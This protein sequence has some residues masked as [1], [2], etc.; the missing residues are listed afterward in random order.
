MRVKREDLLTE[1]TSVKPGLSVK[2]ELMQSGCFVFRKG[3]VITFNEEICCKRPSSL[4]IEGAVKA[5][6]LLMVLEKTKKEYLDLEVQEGQ[7]VLQMK[8]ASAGVVME[9]EIELPVSMVDDPEDWHS[10]SDTFI[11][12]MGMVRHCAG[13]DPS[14]FYL[15]CVHIGDKWVEA[16]DNL[17]IARYR[18][19]TGVSE[20]VLLLAKS[21]GII[22]DDMREV[23]EFSITKSF[24]HFRNSEGLVISCRRYL[25]DFPQLGKHLKFE[26]QNVVLP[27]GAAEAAE[28]AEIFSREYKDYNKV[29]VTISP[30]GMKI[31][32]DGMTGWYTASKRLDYEGESLE[33]GIAPQLLSNLVTKYTDFVITPDRLKV[34]SEEGKFTYITVLSAPTRE[35]EKANGELRKKKKQER[36]EDTD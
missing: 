32:S 2:D 17:Q 34:K 16:A 4:K 3:K 31:R 22:A 13:K 27:K 6:S 23:S 11:K 35:K 26:G 19:E 36:T 15:M 14:K 18:V 24:I 9:K 10:A 29:K 25:E 1:L 21:A 20:D 12:A 28:T 5:H 7:L 33:F 30:G 8:K